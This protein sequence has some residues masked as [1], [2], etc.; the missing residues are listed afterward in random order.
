MDSDDALSASEL[1]PIIGR[2]KWFDATRGFGFLVS[3]TSSRATCCSTSACFASTAGGAFPKARS[4]SACRCARSGGSRP[5]KSFPSTSAR[6]CRSRCARPCLRP[7]ARTAR[8]LPMR[9]ASIEPVEVKWFNRVRGYGFLKRPDD[10]GGED[11]FV[12]METVRHRPSR[13]S[14]AGADHGGA[15]R[16]E[17]QGPDRGRASSPPTH[18]STSRYR[19]GR[20]RRVQPAGTGAECPS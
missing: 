20:A 5:R 8:R 10:S 14:A 4:S 15:D 11:V 6:P 1:P 19:R 9:P 2:V 7:N 18:T 17:R 3:A 13:R 16:A 12:H